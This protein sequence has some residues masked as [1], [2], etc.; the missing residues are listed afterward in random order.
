M[1]IVMG[2]LLSLW[3]YASGH[4][5]AAEGFLSASWV[6]LASVV[7]AV[8]SAMVGFS[9]LYNLRCVVGS[10]PFNGPYLEYTGPGLVALTS[11]YFLF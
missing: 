5:Y 7:H 2:I 6:V 10:N 8:L 11:L 4:W 9:L 1:G 3:I